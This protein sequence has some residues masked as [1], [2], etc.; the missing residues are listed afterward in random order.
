MVTSIVLRVTYGMKISG[1]DDPY[2]LK[3][4]KV[5]EGVSMA[6]M[7]GAFWVEFMPFLRHIPS[8]VPGN[9]TGKFIAEYKPLVESSRNDPYNW[10]RKSVVR[11]SCNAGSTRGTDYSICLQVEGKA[12]P[13]VAS[14]CIR[15]IQS[16]AGLADVEEQHE[17]ATNITGVAY[18][19]MSPDR[20]HCHKCTH[21]IVFFFQHVAGADTV[22][23]A[24]LIVA[25]MRIH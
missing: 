18:A 5:M 11:V 13:S 7:P 9:R 21:C 4:Q 10:V 12:P 8:W 20:V 15:D 22:I 14:S 24:F 23:S 17:I 6:S 1:L 16:S 25:A 19:G 2:V 3:I